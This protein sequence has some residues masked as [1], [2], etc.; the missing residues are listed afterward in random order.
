MLVVVFKTA[1]DVHVCPESVDLEFGGSA[2]FGVS[3]KGLSSTDVTWS[4][5]EENAG[6]LDESGTYTAPM[7]VA[8]IMAAM[9]RAE[10]CI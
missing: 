3:V 2:S 1:L 4:L 5:Q 10:R 9:P 8:P 7:R 6:Q